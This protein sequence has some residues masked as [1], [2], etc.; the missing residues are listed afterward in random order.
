MFVACGVPESKFRATC[1]AIDKLDKVRKKTCFSRPYQSFCPAL[2]SVPLE[3]NKE[4]AAGSEEGREKDLRFAV[5]W[6]L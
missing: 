5:R 6:G 4:T 3:K 1:S 2:K